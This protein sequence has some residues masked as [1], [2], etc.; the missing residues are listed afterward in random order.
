M[1]E[2]GK[3]TVLKIFEKCRCGLWLCKICYFQGRNIFVS[4]III[5][6]IIYMIIIP[7]HTPIVTLVLSEG[8]FSL[9]VRNS[10]CFSSFAFPCYELCNSLPVSPSPGNWVPLLCQFRLFVSVLPASSSPTQT[11]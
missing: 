1:P 6:N 10:M 5:K 7:K 9:S 4:L 8:S 2:S 11:W 3:I